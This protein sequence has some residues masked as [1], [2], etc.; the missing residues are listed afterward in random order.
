MQPLRT[1]LSIEVRLLL[2]RIFPNALN[3]YVYYPLLRHPYAD[4]VLEHIFVFIGL[5]F[6]LDFYFLLVQSLK[7]SQRWK[8]SV[9]SALSWAH[10]L[11]CT[12][13]WALRFPEIHR[14]FVQPLCPAGITALGSCNVKQLL[15]EFF[16]QIPSDKT[17]LTE[18]AQVKYTPTLW[19]GPL[20]EAW[21]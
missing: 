12:C 17:F 18:Q 21:K 9:L 13:A 19:M 6:Y 16:K 7:I 4:S 15:M 5:Q 10:A 11:P 20:Q 2:D 1:L 14:I 3:Q 8:M